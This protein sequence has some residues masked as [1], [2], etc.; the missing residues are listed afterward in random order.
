MP[1]KSNG[2]RAGAWFRAQEEHGPSAR[3]KPPSWLTEDGKR[4]FGEIVGSRAPDLFLPGS[5][6]L[7]AH[8]C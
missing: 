6:E 5:L 1:R 3:P 4:L 8:F 7:L 2:A